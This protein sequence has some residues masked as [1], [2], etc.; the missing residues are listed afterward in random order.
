MNC[1]NSLFRRI[2]RLVLPFIG[3]MILNFTRANP[4]WAEAEASHRVKIVLKTFNDKRHTFKYD[5]TSAQAWRI[6]NS[7]MMQRNLATRAKTGLRPK[8]HGIQRGCSRPGRL[9]TGSRTKS[10]QHQPV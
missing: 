9:E 4:G 3:V 10:P 5:L 8:K 6:E 1:R 7:T 2:V